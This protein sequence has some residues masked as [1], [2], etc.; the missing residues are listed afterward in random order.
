MS[1][2]LIAGA[3]KS[4]TYLIRYLLDTAEKKHGKW[5][6]TIADADI[7][8]IKSKTA[9]FN[10]VDAVEFDITDT[11]QRE[12]LVKKAD[13]VVSL[14]P[15]HLHI[16][17]AKDCLQYKKNLI[18]SSYISEEMKEMDIEVKKAGL[19]F[20]CEMGLDPG[21]DHM[22]ASQLFFSIKKVASYITSFK[23]YCGGLIAPES[24]DNP[25]HYKFSWNPAN[26]VTAG[27][28]GA[29]YLLNGSKVNVPYEHIFE[30]AKKVNVNGTNW[31]YYPNRDSLG[32]I[33]IYDIPEVKTFMRATLRHPDFCKG[34]NILVSLGLTDMTRK[35]DTTNLT[36]VD[37][38]SEAA[39]NPDRDALRQVIFQKANMSETR[40]AN[41]MLNWLGLFDETPIDL[42]FVSSGEILLHLLQQ[43]WEMQPEDRDM[44]IMQHE[45]EYESRFST[46]VITS[47]M[48]VK[49]ENREFS[50]MAKTVGLPM[51]I[52]ADLVV[53]KLIKPPHGVLVPIMPEVYR[54]VLH[55]LGKH[56]IIF[57]ETTMDLER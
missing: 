51:G 16:L 49:G 7:N 3:G 35:M 15:P 22:T 36:F 19:M 37:W 17:L 8:A 10:H 11:K 12:T 40:K 14:M 2:I 38:V 34:W 18:T 52:L 45:A 44:V 50:A 28:A 30:N 47:T 24:D 27:Q 1:Q 57:T 46:T 55:R 32:Y 33:D 41:E 5:K 54:P 43:K 56:G 23:S 25:W 20:M 21:I 53:A 4:S 39:G 42:G 13:L 26:I 6:V 48:T 29:Q 31:A 9:G